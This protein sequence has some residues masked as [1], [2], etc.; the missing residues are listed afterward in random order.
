[1]Y[2]CF[3]TILQLIMDVTSSR[4]QTLKYFHCNCSIRLASNTRPLSSRLMRAPSCNLWLYL[5]KC[6]R[7]SAHMSATRMMSFS[8][9][10]TPHT[11]LTV[12]PHGLCR[13]WTC[14][15]NSSNLIGTLVPCVQRKKIHFMPEAVV[16]C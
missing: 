1:M 3:Y 13:N 6:K 9:A 12:G 7:E 14:R 4:E 5:M 16:R 2:E 11:Q 10:A 8:L 15:K